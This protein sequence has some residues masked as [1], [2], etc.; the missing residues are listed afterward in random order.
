MVDLKT[1]IELI[2]LDSLIPYA[3]NPKEH[4]PEQVQLIVDSIKDYGWDQPI[5]I[6]DD[7]IIIKGHG[8]YQAAQQLGLERVPVIWQNGLT[9]QEVLGARIADNKAKM[10]SGFSYDILAKELGDLEGKYSKGEISDMT[11][12]NKSE[13]EKIG[14]RRGADPSE[15]WPGDENNGDPQG[16][17]Q[18]EAPESGRGS[19]TSETWGGENESGRTDI[20]PG[21]LEC[22]DCGEIFEPTL[23]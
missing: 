12:L 13:V 5:V 20:P 3:S 9:P 15:L 21:H 6:D 18:V 8:R 10:G 23:E 7:G 2:E 1:D 4:P 19:E 22:P 16:R 17:S 11:G 14:K